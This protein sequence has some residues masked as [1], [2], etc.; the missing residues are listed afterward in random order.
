MKDA[1]KLL[2][3]LCSY[4]KKLNIPKVDNS[5]TCTNDI[6]SFFAMFETHA[7]DEERNDVMPATRLRTDE[8]III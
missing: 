6:N 8:R 5:V 7:F 4:N 3:T 2:K 1:W